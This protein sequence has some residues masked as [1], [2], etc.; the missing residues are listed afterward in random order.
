MEG[1]SWNCNGLSPQKLKELARLIASRPLLHFISISEIKRDLRKAENVINIAAV[2][3]ESKWKTKYTH[4]SGP[5]Q[6]LF[7]AIKIPDSGSVFI[8]DHS[9]EGELAHVS[10]LLSSS[11]GYN[12]LSY[13]VRPNNTRL[14]NNFI[15]MFENSNIALGDLNRSAATQPI[16]AEHY[17]SILETFDRV[18]LIESPTFIPHTSQTQE[19]TTT[20]DSCATDCLYNESAY[21]LH[22]TTLCSDHLAVYFSTN[23][24]M[25]F[26]YTRKE[27]YYYDYSALD[28]ADIEA[29]WDKLNNQ[30]SFTEV[31]EIF[32][33]LLLKIKRK[34]NSK[35]V[36][37]LDYDPD[38][39]GSSEINEHWLEVIQGNDNMMRNVAR[40]FQVANRF[41]GTEQALND[42][43]GA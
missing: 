13:Y 4:G 11:G 16:R 18:E 27:A 5:G 28:S 35:I 43:E 34:A 10:T 37:P 1:A 7:T 30:P 26:E 8:D 25:D 3:P 33:L 41:D 22:H 15:H 21:L 32:S 19:P 14:S 2:F 42:K 6:G 29:A 17:D 40:M 38:R 23:F 31:N 39:L 24:S 20:P 12:I 36:D 9:V